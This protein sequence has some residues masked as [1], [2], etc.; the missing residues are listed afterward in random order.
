MIGIP[1]QES[2]GSTVRNEDARRGTATSEKAASCAETSSASK[3]SSQLV[4]GNGEIGN[5]IQKILEC[6]SYDSKE[7]A[8]YL[9][10]Q[11]VPLQY[12]VL[13]ICFPYSEKFTAHV[14]TYQAALSPRLVVVHSTVPLGTCDPQGWVHSPVRGIHPHLEEGIRTFV[15]FFGGDYAYDAAALFRAKGVK[16]M[17]AREARETEALKLWDTTIYGWNILLQKA[18]KDYCDRNGLDFRAVYTLAN[19]TYNSGYSSLAH[20]EFTKYILKD[21]PGPIGG[22]CVRENWELLGDDPI[23]ILSKELHKKLTGE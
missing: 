3:R 12:D 14:R 6:D 19:A 15:K 16:T 11:G 5:A 17:C 9:Y 22:H 10:D 1:T 7:G 4:I 23:A 21:F 20:P 18:I 13:H 8:L 2:T